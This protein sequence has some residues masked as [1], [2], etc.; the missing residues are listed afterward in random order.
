MTS[1]VFWL[2][3]DVAIGILAILL[4]GIAFHWESVYF[5][6]FSYTALI[7]FIFAVFYLLK[8]TEKKE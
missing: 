8:P 6:Y 3:A 2:I 5:T 7:F 4:A 1:N